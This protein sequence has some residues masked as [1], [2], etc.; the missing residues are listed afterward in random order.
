MP[1]SRH[2]RSLL[3]AACLVGAGQ[4]S[5]L[6]IEFDYS[7]DDG[8]TRLTDGQKLV[9][10]SIA[11]E[12][13]ARLTD[14]LDAATYRSVSFYDPGVAPVSVANVVTERNLSVAAD[15]IRVFVA[16][17]DLTALGS[18]TLGAGGPGGGTAN[19]RGESNVGVSDFAPWGGQ[20]SFDTTTTWYVDDD[21]S[22]FEPFSGFDFY[23]VA[24]HEL[25]HVLGIGTSDSWD[26]RVTATGFAGT[27]SVAAY[28]GIVPLTGD[29]AHWA[30]GTTSFVDGLSQQA[31]L[32]AAIAGGTRKHMTELDWAAL[33]DVG[34]QVAA[35]VP[36]PESWAMMLAGLGLVGLSLKR[37][38]SRAD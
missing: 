23:S 32:T 1:T 20:I 33:S 3:A 36:E 13:G 15:T 4:A 21:V 34:W 28:G 37:R 14:T 6:T 8:A 27:A 38:R 2:L 31:A 10:S 24:V 11:A 30:A 9:L 17:A 35:A 29:A 26:A 7:Y 19:D 18:S 5:A 22:T 16:A 25:T 12:F